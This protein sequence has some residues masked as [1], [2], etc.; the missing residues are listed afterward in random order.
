MRR[1]AVFTAILLLFL[2]GAFAVA[3][4]KD[5]EALPGME[6]VRVGNTRLMVPEGAR[7]YKQDGVIVVENA[8]EY[9]TRKIKISEERVEGIN[10]DIEDLQDKMDELKSALDRIKGSSD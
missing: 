8:G 4:E 10:E 9:A 5:I 2:P 3:G 1:I 7:V 6:L